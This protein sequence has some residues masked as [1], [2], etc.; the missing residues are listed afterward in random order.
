MKQLSDEIIIQQIQSGEQR[1]QNQALRQLYK[2][3][4]GLAEQIIV[5]NSGNSEDVPDVFQNALIIFF[6]KAKKPDFQ[7][8]SSIKTFLYSI[9]RNLWLMELR[10]N[11]RNTT[12]EDHHEYIPT[13]ENIFETLVVNEKKK[14]II[15][16]LKQMGES[17]RKVLEMFYFRK[18]KMVQIQKAMGYGSEQVAKNKKR[19]CMVRLRKMVLENPEYVKEL[20][21]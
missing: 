21:E 7:L 20:R 17:C 1:L 4:Y 14:L 2:A 12:L 13:E 16:L 3:F 5:K 19:A 6:N 9:C 8:S 11:K 15:H 10:K 18:M